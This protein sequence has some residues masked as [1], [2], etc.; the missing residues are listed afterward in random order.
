MLLPVVER[1]GSAPMAAAGYDGSSRCSAEKNGSCSADG[2]MQWKHSA[3]E[4]GKNA[5]RK[6]PPAQR[7]RVHAENGAPP[8]RSGAASGAPAP[9]H[10]AAS[11]EAAAAY[12]VL[13]VPTSSAEHLSFKKM[14]EG[15][16]APLLLRTFSSLQGGS[17]PLHPGVHFL[18]RGNGRKARKEPSGSLTSEV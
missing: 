2:R 9:A 17:P 7:R 16:G 10:P 4:A 1:N 18:S 12:T 13:W 14:Q 11:P 6:R 15:E 5:R 8:A 3:V